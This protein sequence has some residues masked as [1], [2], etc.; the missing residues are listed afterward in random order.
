MIVMGFWE[1]IDVEKG[2][3]NMLIYMLVF[4]FK[5]VCNVLWKVFV[6]DLEW[7]KV[8]VELQK[9]GKIFECIE[10]VFMVFID[11]FLVC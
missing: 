5:E 11:Y 4:L 9:D 6:E 3:G 2:K 1:L 8:V 7:K 10:L